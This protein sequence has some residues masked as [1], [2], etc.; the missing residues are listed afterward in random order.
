VAVS[1]VNFNNSLAD[2]EALPDN[3][4]EVFAD[5]A[6]RGNIRGYLEV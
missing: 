5:S 1:F 3:P 2:P 4:G 6:Y